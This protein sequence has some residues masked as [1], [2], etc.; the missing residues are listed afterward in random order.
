MVAG[1]GTMPRRPAADD[2]DERRGVMK[3]VRCCV[4]L[5]DD[6]T[7]VNRSEVMEVSDGGARP[8]EAAALASILRAT[9]SLIPWTANRSEDY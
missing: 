3:A 1:T 7:E 5:C 2:S 9:G 6:G 8:P 4:S